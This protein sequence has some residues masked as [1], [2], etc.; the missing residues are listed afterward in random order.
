MRISKRVRVYKR[1]SSVEF[2]CA[3]FQCVG[4]SVTTRVILSALIRSEKYYREFVERCE[5]PAVELFDLI[6]LNLFGIKGQVPQLCRFPQLFLMEHWPAVKSNR[7]GNS[8]P[9][10]FGKYSS[11]LL[12]HAQNPPRDSSRPDV[13]RKFFESKVFI[14]PST[15]Q[16]RTPRPGPILP[17]RENKEKPQAS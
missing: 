14:D 5:S 1:L 12:P 15:V 8:P 6:F 16:L 2:P 13:I 10:L 9:I 17:R 7:F 4:R 11:C 3:Y